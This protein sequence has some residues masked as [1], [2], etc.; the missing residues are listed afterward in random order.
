MAGTLLS[1]KDRAWLKKLIQVEV[2]SRQNNPRSRAE[3]PW[4]EHIF[5]SSDVYVAKPQSVAG[6]EALDGTTPGKALCDIYQIVWQDD[7]DLHVVTDLVEMVYNVSTTA[8]EQVFIVI[9][10]TKFGVWVTGSPPGEGGETV[11]WGIATQAS[12]DADGSHTCPWVRVNPCDDC[13]GTNPIVSTEIDV[14]LP[15]RAGF[16]HCV[17]YGDVIAY[18]ESESGVYTCDSDYTDTRIKF[19]KA[20]A[21]WDY[22]SGDPLVSVKACD[23]DG[24]NVVGAAFDVFL[25]VASSEDPA[26]FYG[27]VIGFFVDDHDHEVAVGYGDNALGTV[28]E[29]TNSSGDIRVGW[30]LCDG[31]NGTVDL[32]D[33]FVPAAGGDY[34]LGATGGFTWHGKTHNN[35][36]NHASGVCMPLEFQTDEGGGVWGWKILSSVT[37]PTVDHDGPY[38][39]GDDTDNRPPYYALYY[40]ERVK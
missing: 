40:I 14:R 19:G 27:D 23:R 18:S 13:I 1:E 2:Q 35:H 28:V 22:N 20:Q 31:K 7:D 39:S 30:A 4:N 33:S 3:F 6:I 25:S 5:Q 8:I 24:T 26:V 16:R 12:E 36:S 17:A 9:Y 11:Q 21:D 10:R 15:K 34:A 32:L 38:N 29:W 37:Y